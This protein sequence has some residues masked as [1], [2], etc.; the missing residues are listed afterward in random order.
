MAEQI[1]TSLRLPKCTPEELRTFILL[2]NHYIGNASTQ[3]DKV[4][5][6]PTVDVIVKAQ[7][8]LQLTKG[9]RLAKKLLSSL[10]DFETQTQQANANPFPTI[11]AT[12]RYANYSIN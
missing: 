5:N 10:Y 2:L 9:T 12:T 8:C 7:Y 1:I 4:G 11:I 6:D 3:M